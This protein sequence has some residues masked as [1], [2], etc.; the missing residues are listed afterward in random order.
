MKRTLLSIIAA[1]TISQPAFAQADQAGSSKKDA[2]AITC[3]YA[4]VVGSRIPTR[5]CLTNFEW[6]D[7]RRAQMEAK[8]SSKNRNS[9]CSNDSGPC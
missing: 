4:K 8:R 6:E 3:K 9:Y 2:E 7:R 1:L 5:V